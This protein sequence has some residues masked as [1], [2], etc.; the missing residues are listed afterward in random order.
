MMLR[1]AQR[2]LSHLQ[3]CEA[4]AAASGRRCPSCLPLLRHP[5][6]RCGRHNRSQRQ[7]Q[8]AT[9]ECWRLLPL[10]LRRRARLRQRRQLP[11]Q[12]HCQQAA[13][14]QMSS[15]AAQPLRPQQTGPQ[16]QQATV[17]SAAAELPAPKRRQ[18]LQLPLQRRRRCRRRHRPRRLRRHSHSHWL[19]QRRHRHH[20]HPRSLGR[21]RVRTRG[22]GSRAQQGRR[23]RRHRSRRH[24][25][26]SGRLQSHCLLR[27]QNRNTG[28]R[29]PRP[30]CQRRQRRLMIRRSRSRARSRV[31]RTLTR[32][33]HR[34]LMR[35]LQR[36]RR[37]GRPEWQRTL[38]QRRARPARWPARLRCVPRQA[39]RRSGRLRRGRHWTAAAVPGLQ[40][41][42]QPQRVR[43]GL[44]HE[45]L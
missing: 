23:R 21:D 1:L 12:R 9:D 29:L 6:C 10:R 18:Q 31:H 13:G 43:A 7:R 8:R 38:P 45:P 44:R 27:C 37:G 24:R 5:C 15:P 16:P 2:A 32:S 19:R 34:Q 35:Q 36:R 30:R 33:H 17:Y 4:R 14:R 26:R 40:P 20:H 42:V 28:R 22:R 25:N 41:A 11:C 3:R 39:Q